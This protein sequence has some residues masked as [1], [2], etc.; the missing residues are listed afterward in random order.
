MNKLKDEI[1]KIAEEAIQLYCMETQRAYIE[2]KK[3][4]ISLTKQYKGREIYELL[5]NIDDAADEKKDCKADIVFDGEYLTVSN[6]GHPFTISTLQR[7]CQGGVS[8][9]ND[10]YIGCKGIGFRSIL[11]WSDVIEIYS[12]E[13][14]DYIAV[15][16]S[17]DYANKK[18]DFLMNNT[19]ESIKNHLNTQIDELKSKGID[20]SYPIFRAP[21][22]IDQ[23]IDKE[24]DTVIKLKIKDNLIDD[25]TNN[26]NDIDR[27]RYILLFLPHLEQIKISV[28]GNPCLEFTKKINKTNTVQLTIPSEERTMT[29]EDFIYCHKEEKL[30]KKYNGS[31]RI[32][33][34]VAI[35]CDNKVVIREPRLYTFFPILDLESPFPALLH[36]TFFLTDNRNDLDLN[37]EET[38]EANKEIFKRLLSF[39]IEN[40]INNVDK[41][42]RLRLLLPITMP[43]NCSE[44]F[45]FNG[46]L[47]KL[48][49]ELVYIDICKKNKLFFTVNNNYKKVSDYP[50]VL[51]SCPENEQLFSGDYFSRLVTYIHD[52]KERGFAKRLIGNNNDTESYLCCAI[53]KV[54]EKW[55]ASERIS[56]FKWWH[57]QNYT[58]LPNLLKTI[59]D[60]FLVNNSEPCF[61]PEDNVPVWVKNI[62]KWATISILHEDDQK[63]LLTVYSKEIEENKNASESSKRVLARIINKQL[64]DIQEQSSRQMVISPVNTSVNGNYDYAVEFMEWLWQVWNESRFDDTIKNKISFVVP[65]KEKKVS[66]AKNVYMG[67]SYDNKLGA[68]IFEKIGTYDDKYHELAIINIEP[69]DDRKRA[70]LQ[71]LGVL[72]YPRLRLDKE[73]KQLNA[74]TEIQWKYVEYVLKNHPLPSGQEK[75]RAFNTLLFSIDNIEDIL[76]NLDTKTIISWIFRDLELRNA[77]MNDVQPKNCCI[78]YLLPKKWYSLRHNNEWQLPSYIRFVFSIV[79]WIDIKG[80]KYSP[81]EL[82]ITNNDFLSSFNLNCISESEIEDFAKNICDKDELRQLLII[83]GAKT[84]YLELDAEEFY[85]LLLALP[86]GDEIKAKKIS[87][88]LYRTI[89]DSS[90]N[91]SK[92]KSLYETNSPKREEFEKSGQVLV[93][94]NGK[95][96]FVPLQNA[97]FSSSAVINIDEKYPID[98]PTRRGKREDFQN[99]LRIQPFEITYSVLSENVSDCNADFQKELESY[100]PCIMAYRRGKKDEVLNLTIE[101]VKEAKI[102]YE[103]NDRKITSRYALLKKANRHW[104]I[105]VGEETEYKKLEKELIADNLVQIFNVLFNFPSKEFLNKV[106]Q[107][108]IYSQRQR[109]HYIE[110]ELGSIEEIEFAK[111][112]IN[113]SKDFYKKLEEFFKSA[114]N[115][116]EIIKQINWNNLS[117]SDQRNVINLLAQSGRTLEDLNREIERTISVVP[118]NKSVLGNQ[119]KL[120]RLNVYTDI[121]AAIDK[122]GEHINLMSKWKEFEDRVMSYNEGFES[123]DFKAEDTYKKLKNEFYTTNNITENDSIKYEDIKTTYDENRQCLMQFFDN[124]DL[125]LNDFTNDSNNNSLLFFKDDKLI[126]IVTKFIEE[127]SKQENQAE[128]SNIDLNSLI[129]NAEIQNDL[130][131]GSAMSNGNNDSNKGAVTRTKKE[132]T[133]RKNKRQGN[134]AEYIVVLKLAEKVIPEVNTFFNDLDYSIHWVSGAAKD[135]Q[136]TSDDKHQYDCSMTDDGAGYDIK[137]VS[138][139]E[140]KTMYIEVK[141]SSSK[142]CS[143]YMSLNEYNFAKSKNAINEQYRIIF[144]SNINVNDSSSIPKIAF[145]DASLEDAFD[146]NAIQYNMIYNKE[147][148][149]KLKR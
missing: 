64:V 8:E 70:F 88:E 23:Q 95:S 118:Y 142:N 3:K 7:L 139:D 15:R 25:I 5:Q 127:Q 48:G 89:I 93:K 147:K 30:G 47:A 21:E 40:V 54:S 146:S 17:R 144:V 11:N 85:G 35:P 4:E 55:N 137:L 77:I 18:L 115:A 103:G 28:E 45:L 24:F 100:I 29:T 114:Q 75:P 57:S 86:N 80:K 111:Q 90:P 19:S 38:K 102:N 53:N 67:E 76:Q 140:D 65:T 149:N 99:I 92:Y 143:F 129:K 107:L 44:T 78:E 68:M 119:Y 145:I 56:V 69:F 60:N 120:D 61:L 94:K 135:I 97:F 105:Y 1:N 37:S 109:E 113:Q 59:D 84:S 62:P 104:L 72:K 39:Y 91:I 27:Y 41:E 87:K 123:I 101:L 126:E 112:E 132:K 26:L 20:S 110:D 13:G 79:K 83:L 9:K 51:D 131:S 130:S 71:D 73:A 52:D 136:T 32:S 50:I 121:Y 148:L 12:G 108:F 6:N 81:I 141:S 133:E 125:S 128:N 22:P 98:I 43:L 116:S 46:S 138:K 74:D 66:E 134:I 49:L 16:F 82:I 96:C 31:D 122:S 124:T 117:I 63:E 34:G 36:A 42:E 10:Q 14:N 106:E 58:T 33:M 2:D